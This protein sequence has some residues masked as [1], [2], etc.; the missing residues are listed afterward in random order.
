MQLKT[1]NAI[2]RLHRPNYADKDVVKKIHIRPDK[3]DLT[4]SDWIFSI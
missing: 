3:K 4:P 2:R 1:M